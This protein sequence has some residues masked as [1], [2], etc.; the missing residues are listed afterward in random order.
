MKK[1]FIIMVMTFAVVS[2]YAQRTRITAADL[3]GSI[4]DNVSRDHAGFTVRDAARIL[5]D[6]VTTYE[7]VIAKGTTQET[8]LYDQSGKYIKKTG[9]KQGTV[10]KKYPLSQAHKKAPAKAQTKK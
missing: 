5:K 8:L 3:P 7:V 6:N 4:I 1:L 2:A 9:A 10:S